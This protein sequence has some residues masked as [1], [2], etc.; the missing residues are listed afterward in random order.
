QTCEFHFSYG[1]PRSKNRATLVIYHCP[2]CGG[3]APKSKRH[4][5]FAVIPP[6]EEERLAKLLV[7]VKTIRSALKTLGKPQRDDPAGTHTAQDEAAGKSP[8]RQRHRTLV[9]E[10]LSKVADVWITERNDGSTSWQLVGKY[11][12]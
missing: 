2:F 6:D 9:Y 10:G 11:I 1:D 4:L 8:V 7:P 12:G 3:A 5:L